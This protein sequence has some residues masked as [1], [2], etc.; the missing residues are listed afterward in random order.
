LSEG[1]GKELHTVDDFFLLHRDDTYGSHDTI[2]AEIKKSP[3]SDVGVQWS[4]GA[5]E[6]L[7]CT[8]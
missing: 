5:I 1:E 8:I 3:P 4:D 2:L 7:A 6:I